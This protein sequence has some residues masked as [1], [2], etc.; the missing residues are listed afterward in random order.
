MT[1]K[2]VV[3]RALWLVLRLALSNADMKFE[4]CINQCIYI[5][6]KISMRKKLTVIK[7]RQ[8]KKYALSVIQLTET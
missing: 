8:I 4:S 5:D 2:K 7:K 1:V 6:V 3:L